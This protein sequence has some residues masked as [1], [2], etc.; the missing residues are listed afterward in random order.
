MPRRSREERTRLTNT[1]AIHDAINEAF[2][3]ILADEQHRREMHDEHV[4]PIQKAINKAFKNL[5]AD[6]DIPAKVL[7]LKF[8]EYLMEQEALEFE[9][10]NDRDKVLDGLKLAFGAMVKGKTL[11]Y[12]DVLEEQ[13][14]AQAAE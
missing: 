9:D 13:G 2:P 7:K 1:S 10:E 4:K 14:F 8:K 3:K 6:C 12:L 11:N 5:S